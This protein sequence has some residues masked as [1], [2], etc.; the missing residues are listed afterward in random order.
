MKVKGSPPAQVAR[1]KGKVATLAVLL[2]SLEGISFEDIAAF[3]ESYEAYKQH[4][5]TRHQ[6]AG[7]LLRALELALQLGDADLTLAIQGKQA[8]PHIL[9]QLIDQYPLAAEAIQARYES[10][11]Q[12]TADEQSPTSPSHAQRRSR[13]RVSLT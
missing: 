7:E 9:R 1:N 12:G 6:D 10:M 5:P 13:F 4:F 3:E 2:P 8:S 11:L